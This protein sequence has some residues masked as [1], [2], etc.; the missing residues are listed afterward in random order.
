[1][2]QTEENQYQEKDRAAK[3]ENEENNELPYIVQGTAEA[4]VRVLPL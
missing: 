3:Y 2:F 4:P 1:M